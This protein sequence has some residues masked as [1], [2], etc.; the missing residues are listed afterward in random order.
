MIE[1]LER[2]FEGV[3]I[4]LEVELRRAINSAAEVVIPKA[5]GGIR[6]NRWWNRELDD[7]KREVVQLKARLRRK[8]GVQE[9][10]R[11]LS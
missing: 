3:I 10:V 1:K 6:K 5:R 2:E 4:G 8:K 7:T 11:G 9:S